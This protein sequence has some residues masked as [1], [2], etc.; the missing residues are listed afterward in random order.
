M[1][2]GYKMNETIDLNDIYYNK[3]RKDIDPHQG[4]ENKEL[5]EDIYL[6]REV[7]EEHILQK[8]SQFKESKS[9]K[10]V[11]YSFQQKKDSSIMNLL[12]N[13]TFNYET[14]MTYFYEGVWNDFFILYSKYLVQNKEKDPIYRYRSYIVSEIL[15]SLKKG[16][17]LF[18]NGI[19]SSIHYEFYLDNIFKNRDLFLN[20]Y[21]IY[22]LGN[23]FLNMNKDKLLNSFSDNIKNYLINNKQTY[24]FNKIEYDQLISYLQKKENSRDVVHYSWKLISL[25]TDTSILL[26][27]SCYLSDPNSP[28]SMYHGQRGILEYQEEL[29]VPKNIFLQI[30]NQEET[31]LSDEGK[32]IVFR[33]VSDAY[34]LISK[35][36]LLKNEKLG[37][38]Q[39]EFF[40]NKN[41]I[42]LL[43]YL[44]H[45]LIEL[46]FRLCWKKSSYKY[47]K[48]STPVDMIKID[49][50]N[51]I[52]YYQI[53]TKEY[54][55]NHLDK[56]W[57]SGG[58][59]KPLND[60]TKNIISTILGP[61][62]FGFYENEVDV[63]FEFKLPKLDELAKH[64]RDYYNKL[65]TTLINKM[66]KPFEQS[67]NILERISKLKYKLQHTQ[68]TNEAIDKIMK[69]LSEK[70]LSVSEDSV[71]SP[72]DTKDLLKFLE[73]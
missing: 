41:P 55:N 36:N 54:A 5:A 12:D 59:I 15:A 2:E 24:H 28:V 10:N 43:F 70:E 26:N 64:N 4:I 56:F 44:C 69:K 35:N 7:S 47:I 23:Y 33:L 62:I 73:Q 46:P 9:P 19:S 48:T 66:R 40:Y 6:F 68:N 71:F 67:N 50:V 13:E 34:D 32:E 42:F 63:K 38:R 37:K 61:D 57:E 72:N 20:S 11:M 51:N 39:L 45:H 27:R 58:N 22:R 16:E 1:E 31:H 49:K 8:A 14:I 53:N 29:Y 25:F 21:L 3:I 30:L 18:K 60:Q 52:I 17:T 65:I